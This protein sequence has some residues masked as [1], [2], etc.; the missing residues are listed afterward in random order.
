MDSGKLGVSEASKWP[1]ERETVFLVVL[2]ILPV[3]LER[4]N[5]LPCELSVLE[6]YHSD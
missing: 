1:H 5:R 3:Y 2:G 4:E 6:E